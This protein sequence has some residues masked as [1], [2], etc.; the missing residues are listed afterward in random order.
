M[1]ARH[2]H[3]G[4]GRGSEILASVAKW[5]KNIHSKFQD[6]SYHS[7]NVI[8]VLKPNFGICTKCSL[9]SDPITI[10]TSSVRPKLNSGLTDT[11]TE[12]K[13]KNL[14]WSAI[15]PILHEFDW[16]CV[17]SECTI[18]KFWLAILDKWSEIGQWPAVI[19]H[20]APRPQ[21]SI[22]KALSIITIPQTAVTFPV[23][24]LINKS[25]EIWFVGVKVDPTDAVL[26][27]VNFREVAFRLRL[28]Y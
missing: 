23:A 16:P 19:L 10:H 26:W 27:G 21:K 6:C 13:M 12:C 25:S 9:F 14:K 5:S 24:K 22:S 4:S 8:S 7:F 15:F 17:Q 1:R 11:P 20:S 2:T 28:V 3:T 18:V